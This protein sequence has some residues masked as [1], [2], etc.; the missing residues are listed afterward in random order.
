MEIFPQLRGFFPSH[1][2]FSLHT[3]GEFSL[4]MGSFPYLWGI[5]PHLLGFSSAYED[6]SPLTDICL[7]LRIFVPTYGYLSPLT[8]GRFYED[9]LIIFLSG[10]E[11]RTQDPGPRGFGYIMATTWFK[12]V[13]PG[14][15]SP[16][17]PANLRR[18]KILLEYSML[19]LTKF[20]LV[21]IPLF[22]RVFAKI[23]NPF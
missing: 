1:G 22:T 9:P 5:F 18:H 8:C 15:Q 23:V 21:Y 14:L 16:T 10:W 20:F 11:L 3:Y 7:H 4:L 13:P 17:N 2:Q 12:D 19:F 6:F